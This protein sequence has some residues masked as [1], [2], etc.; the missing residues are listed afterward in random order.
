MELALPTHSRNA[1]AL[2]KHTATLD[3]PNVIHARVAALLHSESCIVAHPVRP[4]FAVRATTVI[5]IISICGGPGTRT[6]KASNFS[7]R[8]AKSM[9]RGRV[10]P[11]SGH[12]PGTA[13]RPGQA[14]L[15]DARHRPGGDEPQSQDRQAVLGRFVATPGEPPCRR[16]G[17]KRHR[18]GGDEP[19]SQD[20]QAVLG[21][22]VA[23][24]GEP[25]C[26]R[27]W[28]GK[29]IALAE[30]NHIPRIGKP[31]WAGLSQHP[32]NPAASQMGG[33]GKDIALAETNHNPR[34]GKPSWAGWFQHQ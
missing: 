7:S 2:P 19:Q 1:S 12:V 27:R 23:T 30:T 29:D 32:A 14:R 21:R 10:P 5:V 24:P 11:A 15:L 22:F 4:D 20:R 25:P 3:I 9:T 28:G 17:G 6:S 18:P 13:S 31:S 33:M 8:E 16:R 26:R 34:I